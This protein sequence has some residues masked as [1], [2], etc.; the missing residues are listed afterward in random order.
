MGDG[1]PSSLGMWGPSLPLLSGAVTTVSFLQTEA[2][3]NPMAGQEGCRAQ[4]W[5][6]GRRRVRQPDTRLY[7]LINLC[8]VSLRS[9]FNLGNIPVNN[10]I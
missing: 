6:S 8:G 1:S 9:D 5:P 2:L 4:G 3:S 7:A 10:N